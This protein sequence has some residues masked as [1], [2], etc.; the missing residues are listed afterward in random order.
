[1]VH[2]N[3]QVVQ[4]T[5]RRLVT[6]KLFACPANASKCGVQGVEESPGDIAC[7]TERIVNTKGPFDHDTIKLL[8]CTPHCGLALF[9]ARKAYEDDDQTDLVPGCELEFQVRCHN[10][11]PAAASQYIHIFISAAAATD[12]VSKQNVNYL[13]ISRSK[14][15][16]NGS[17]VLPLSSNLKILDCRG[18]T[19]V[20]DQSKAC[21]PKST[22]YNNLHAF[23]KYDFTDSDCLGYLS[24]WQSGL[25][26]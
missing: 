8:F 9:R 7:T 16:L 14:Q 10:P 23:L 5:M 21:F 1:M 26:L 2:D 24:S 20:R 25:L 13:N 15:P 6:W 4:T 22:Q 11:P 19:K 3:L 18:C 12:S 17:V